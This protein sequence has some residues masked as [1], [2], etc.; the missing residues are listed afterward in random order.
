MEGR[1]GGMDRGVVTWIVGWMDRQMD[2]LLHGRMD[3]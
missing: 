1:I 2:G 3:G